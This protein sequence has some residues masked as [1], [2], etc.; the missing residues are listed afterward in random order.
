MM[1][2]NTTKKLQWLLLL[3]TLLIAIASPIIAVDR[4][5][6]SNEFTS[7]ASLTMAKEAK[8]IALEAK[9]IGQANA[10]DLEYFKGKLEGTLTG[11]L[12][13]MVNMT[14]SQR[15]A[16]G[17]YDKRIDK[18]E[19]KMDSMMQILVRFKRSDDVK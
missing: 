11:V 5:N 12:N 13:S 17:R 1:A 19:S 9:Q 6:N 4:A 8:T 3:V 15:D 7:E 14:A 16:S 2:D 10:K 18:L